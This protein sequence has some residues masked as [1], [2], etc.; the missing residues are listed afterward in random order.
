M[1]RSALSAHALSLSKGSLRLVFAVHSYLTPLQKTVLP[2][3]TGSGGLDN[4]KIRGCFPIR[5]PSQTIPSG[6]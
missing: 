5:D 2:F 6:E 3:L 4:E 1:K